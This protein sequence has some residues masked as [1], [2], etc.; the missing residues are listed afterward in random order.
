MG[1]QPDASELLRMMEN[2]MFLSQMNEAMNNPAVI[3]MMRNSPMV[4]NNPMARQMLENP[5]LRRTMFSPEMIRMQLQLQRQMGNLGGGSAFPAPG[6]TDTTPQDAAATPGQGTN[7]TENTQQ[8]PPTNPFALFGNTGAGSQNPFAAL[9][10]APPAA[11][12][13]PATSPPPPVSAGQGAPATATPAAAEAQN[14]ANPFANLFGTGMGTGMPGQ[15]ALQ[16]GAQ[17]PNPFSQMAQ[18]LMQNPEAMRSMMQ[19]MGGMGGAG[20]DGGGAYPMGGLF[21]PYAGQPAA[22][23]DNRPPEERYAEQ[24]RQLNDM[25][26]YEFER[27]VQALRRSGGS[28]QGAVEYLLNG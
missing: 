27:N 20:G 7:T 5:E 15:A 1:A 3:N 10:G 28:V 13:T 21:N 26:F 8:Q 17:Q 24:L 23:P 11:G 25:G 18:Q 9:F 2:P 6:A 16:G 22:P 4:R 14:A 19:M 12:V